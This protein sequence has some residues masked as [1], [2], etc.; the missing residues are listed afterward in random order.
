MHRAH[1]IAAQRKKR[2]TVA[3][4]ALAALLAAVLVIHVGAVNAQGSAPI[5]LATTEDLLQCLFYPDS[6]DYDLGGDY[7]LTEDLELS[8]LPEAIG[9]NSRPFTGRFDGGGHTISGLP[10]PL[11]GVT[12]GAVVENLLLD[13]SCIQFPHTYFDGQDYVDGYAPLIAYAVDTEVRN[14]GGAGDIYAYRPETAMFEEPAGQENAEAPAAP[15]PG[16]TPG[17][18]PLPAASPFETPLPSPTAGQGA[19]GENGQGTQSPPPTT[20]QP[21]PTATPALE[22]PQA[23]AE[24]GGAEN[25][26]GGQTGPPQEEAPATENSD[27][28]EGAAQT[29][30][31]PAQPPT[32]LLQKDT[33]AGLRAVL[34]TGF[35]E[36]GEVGGETGEPPAPT[37]PQPEAPAPTAEPVPSALPAPTAAPTETPAPTAEPVSSASPAPTADPTE[38]PAPT[39]EPV[40]SASPVPTAAPTETPAPSLPPSPTPGGGEEAGQPVPPEQS[41]I[42][43]VASRVCA[44]GLVA[45]AEGST[46]ILNCFSLAGVSSQLEAEGSEYVPVMAGC[47]AALVG[48]KARVENCFATG[49]MDCTD[50]S[51]GFVAENRGLIQNSFT[52]ATLAENGNFRAAFAARSVRP[53]GEESEWGEPQSDEPLRGILGCVYDRQMACAEDVYA[54]GLPSAQMAGATAQRPEGSWYRTENAYPQ[55]GYFAQHENER[56]A[57]CSK[58]AAVAAFLPEDTALSDALAAGPAL[59]IVLPQAIDEVALAWSVSGEL[60]LTPAGNAVPD[61]AACLPGNILSG[62]VTCVVGETARTRTLASTPAQPPAVLYED[63]A[64]VGAAVANGSLLRTDGAALTP[65]G[66]GTADDPWQIGTPEALA[67]FMSQVNAG[68]L[69]TGSQNVLLTADIDLFGGNYTGETDADDVTKALPWTPVGRA[70]APHFTGTLDGAGHTVKHLFIQDASLEGG[71]LIGFAQE[72]V[73][74]GVTVGADS[75]ITAR[76]AGGVVGRLNGGTLEDCVNQAAITVSGGFGGGL[77]GECASDAAPAVIRR[78]ANEGRIA[79]EGGDA[80]LGGIAGQAGGASGPPEITD[81]CN[82]GN[83]EKK[84]AGTG[85]AAG[86]ATGSAAIMN[87]YNAGSVTAATPGFASALAEAGNPLAN[88]YCLEGGTAQENGAVPVTLGQLR[89]WGMVYALNGNSRSGHWQLGKGGAPAPAAAPGELRAAADWAE[90]GE[91]VQISGRAPLTATDL[92]AGIEIKYCPV[93]SAE[94]LAWYAYMQNG[95]GALPCRELRIFSDIDLFGGEYTGKRNDGDAEEALP[96]KPIGAEP[97]HGY[98]GFLS[99]RGKQITNLYV[100]NENYAGL[101]GYVKGG[102]VQDLTVQGRVKGVNAGGIAGACAG[103]ISRCRNEAAIAGTG[104]AGGIAGTGSSA[105]T[106]CVNAGSVSGS[107]LTGGLVG[108]HTAGAITDCYN[109]GSVHADSAPAAGGLVGRS[110]GRVANSYV[111]AAMTGTAASLGAFAG[112]AGTAGYENCHYRE[113]GSPATGAGEA[114]GVTAQ[115]EAFMQSRA[116]AETLNTAARVG[117]DSVWTVD[118]PAAQAGQPAQVQS[119]SRVPAARGAENLVQP[120]AAASDNGGYPV[121]GTLAVTIRVVMPSSFSFCVAPDVTVSGPEDLQ[122]STVNASGEYRTVQNLSDSAI[123]LSVDKVTASSANPAFR[124]VSS[125]AELTNEGSVVMALLPAGTKLNS[126]EEYAAKT[127]TAAS[128]GVVVLD[129]LA[130]GGSAELAVYAAAKVTGKENYFDFTV[131]PTIKIELAA[132]G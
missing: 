39:A 44:G 127:L 103:N 50:V 90:V 124:L 21:E 59:E 35:A 73:I 64:A 48:D 62:S 84:D 107:G 38:T 112:E 97:Q 114:P 75:S 28:E 10:R 31:I 33:A 132:G 119:R 60:T 101:L 30:E 1:Q 66:E 16:R 61:P 130:A 20:G 56:F 115:T 46:L 11:F 23:T 111:A 65:A 67:W 13:K 49:Q 41:Y 69:G 126:L 71:G 94:D 118:T 2:L 86:I 92:T 63:W 32:P 70:G 91:W 27:P 29:A 45:Q 129:R 121:F 55:I 47:F 88:C 78:C 18:S 5:P 34:D 53:E 57:L 104:S 42:A 68:V 99:G 89:S 15:T 17:P 74:R 25:G 54:A 9:N 24:P 123:R 12:K 81:C 93:S 14:C 6:P 102:A 40:P 37:E 8:G 36:T 82:T 19:E 79:G 76:T 96:W 105:I 22:Q 43:V 4:G 51:A 125:V 3:A 113:S 131:T 98:V 58:A 52:T 7:V 128:T 80:R 109:T 83:V 26:Q 87:S 110:N 85:G 72:A 108:E 117:P 116:F 106:Q 100:K 95:G 120:M 77:A 122:R